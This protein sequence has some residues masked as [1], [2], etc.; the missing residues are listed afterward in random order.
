MAKISEQISSSF[1]QQIE[2]M[3]RLSERMGMYSALHYRLAELRNQAVVRVRIKGVSLLIRPRTTDIKVAYRTLSGEFDDLVKVANPEFDG[4]IIDAGGYIGTAA[5]AMSKLFPKAKIATIEPSSAS[6]E[7][8]VKNVAANPNIVPIKAALAAEAGQSI[9]LMDQGIGK[10][11]LSIVPSS[12][13]TKKQKTVEYATTVTL[14]D[15]CAQ[16]QELPLGILKLDVEGAER[17]LFRDA[18]AQLSAVPVLFAELHERFV[19]GCEA[20]FD[21]F[22]AKREVY[23]LGYEKLLSIDS[24]VAKE[25]NV[26]LTTRK[27]RE[28][29]FVAA[30]S[31]RIC[32]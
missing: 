2:H 21:A 5:I 27:E 31:V 1:S 19:E 16:F 29:A 17:D 10:W 20:A 15:I 32:Q 26:P 24:A 18:A 25:L 7:L 6:F 3:A 9:A 14:D 12:F 23:T 11:G 13:P 4:L 30:R 28:N 22:S 8:L